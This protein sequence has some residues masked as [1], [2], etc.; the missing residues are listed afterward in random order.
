[1]GCA[2]IRRSGCLYSLSVTIKNSHFDLDS[3]FEDDIFSSIN[4]EKP[5]DIFQFN[6]M[7]KLKINKAKHNFMSIYADKHGN[8]SS[9][10]QH[11][12]T[13]YLLKC[14]AKEGYFRYFNNLN[15]IFFLHNL[16][17]ELINKE[18]IENKISIEDIMKKYMKRIKG[19]YIQQGYNELENILKY[20]KTRTKMNILTFQQT[21]VEKNKLENNL[22]MILDADNFDTYPL[23]L[24][25][26]K[27]RL[28]DKVYHI[29]PF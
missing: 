7:F 11:K 24:E 18:Y 5:L 29:Q 4:S 3:D 26:T 1:M 9:I 14:K 21:I 13:F 25:K 17:L 12:L 19:C 27:N 2:N 28:F 15:S 6:T 8:L 16:K 20:G 22:Y 23:G 10:N